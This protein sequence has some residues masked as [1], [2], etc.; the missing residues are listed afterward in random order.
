MLF[1]S[2]SKY[3]GLCQ[4]PKIYWMQKNKPEEATPP[5]AMK[6]MR[7]EEGHIVGE[8]A[9][10]L[11]GE[12]A[13]MTTYM[14]EA[15]GGNKSLDIKAMIAKTKQAMK[16]GVPV[17]CEAAISTY[18][19]YCAV[20]I[21][22]AENGGWAI[23]EVKSSK[24]MKPAYLT[25]IAYQKYVLE[26][27]GIKVSGTYLVLINGDYVREGDLD[28]QNYFNIVDVSEQIASDEYDCVEHVIND[29][30]PIAESAAEPDMPIGSQCLKPYK[31]DFWEYCSR[32]IPSP[33]AL[34]L[35]RFNKDKAL[36]LCREGKADFE[37]MVKNGEKLSAIQRMQVEHELNDLPTHIDKDGIKAFLDKLN[38]P[39]FFLDFETMAPVIPLF[40]GDGSRQQIPFQ[41]SLHY[42]EE[43]SGE[44]MHKAFLAE[45]GPDPRR[46]V[47]EALCNDIPFG[48]CTMVYNAT[49]ESNRIKELAKAFP[50]LAE[51]LLDIN[52][53]IVDLVIP[54]RDGYYY[55]RNMT[56]PVGPALFSIKNV[57][58][59]IFPDDPDMD[60]HNLEGV[61]NGAEAMK[62]FPEIQFMEP[63]EQER[64]RQELLE[65]CGLDTLAM[66]KV[67]Q[68]LKRLIH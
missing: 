20:D 12:S 13:D 65:Y 16:K 28:V 24:E 6:M 8:F 63:E 56:P 47:A 38:Y 48:A 29:A 51:H 23:Y 10:G 44:L 67:W 40:D 14:E 49:M 53:G 22:K 35:Y 54:F 46:A 25:D 52:K 21:L 2:K 31:C 30:A 57:L 32:G 34:D 5:D 17:I 62:I 66:V 3:T 59:S 18:G 43:E 27:C 39:L 33:S 41:Y 36:E 50:D 9:K 68:E 64:V 19:H 4:C 61:Q 42:V 37:S 45:S 55:S 1:L 11:F 15:D 26:K 7:F 58:P 60:Y